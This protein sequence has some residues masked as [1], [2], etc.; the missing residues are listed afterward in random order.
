MRVYRTEPQVEGVRFIHD[1]RLN[2]KKEKEKEDEKEPALLI[3]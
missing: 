1:I 3:R 2:K